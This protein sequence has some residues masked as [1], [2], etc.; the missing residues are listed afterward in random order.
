M[1]NTINV[2]LT[3]NDDQLKD[4]IL[5]NIK[6]L[7]QEKLQEILLQSIKEILTSKEG[8]FLFMSESGYYSK[9]KQPSQ[10]LYNL[11]Q[12]SNINEV[13]QPIVHQA[14]MKFKEDYPEILEKCLKQSITDM[15]IN[16]LR[17]SQLDAAWDHIINHK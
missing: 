11:I 16:D 4:L 9:E 2:Q 14:V 5:G 7:P 12:K 15:F 8:Q 13:I 3:L 6:E 1:E 10:L 17:Q